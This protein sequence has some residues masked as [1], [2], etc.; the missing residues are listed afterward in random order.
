MAPILATCPKKW[1]RLV[2]MSESICGVEPARGESYI[3]IRNMV[4]VPNPKNTS[5]ADVVKGS[6]PVFQGSCQSMP[7]LQ[8]RTEGS[9]KCKHDIAEL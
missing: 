6:D 2:W 9:V 3:S 7:M 4:C 1:R 5:E 8:N